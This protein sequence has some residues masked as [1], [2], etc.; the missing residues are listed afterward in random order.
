M[1]SLLVDACTFALVH[2]TMYAPYLFS[3]NRQ[4][5]AEAKRK[6]KAPASP[7]RQS[8]RKRPQSSLTPSKVQKTLEYEGPEGSS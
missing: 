3:N 1:L 5:I 6:D 4:S 2:T 8:P 7:R